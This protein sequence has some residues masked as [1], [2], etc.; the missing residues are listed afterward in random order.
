M[1]DLNTTQMNDLNKIYDLDVEHEQFKQGFDD[2]VNNCYGP[3]IDDKGWFLYQSGR[4]A[5]LKQQ[6]LER[7]LQSLPPFQRFLS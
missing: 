1:N 6:R 7:L 2:A 3:P 5:G 4:E